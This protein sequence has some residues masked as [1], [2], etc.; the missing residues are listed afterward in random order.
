MGLMC[1]L[2]GESNLM[3]QM[4]FGQPWEGHFSLKKKEC[5][6]LFWGFGFIYKL[7]MMFFLKQKQQMFIQVASFFGDSSWEFLSLSELR[8]GK[9]SEKRSKRQVVGGF[10]GWCCER[11][12]ELAI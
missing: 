2:E 10:T 8:R 9:R 5:M 1:W 7:W 12:R 3:L 4:V 11:R 6:K